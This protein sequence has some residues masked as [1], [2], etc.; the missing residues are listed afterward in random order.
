[1]RNIPFFTAHT[2]HKYT[3][4]RKLRKGAR[5][6]ISYV[7]IT[8]RQLFSNSYAL[9]DLLS[10]IRIFASSLSVFWN[11]NARRRR[12]SQKYPPRV[13][14]VY[15]VSSLLSPLSGSLMQTMILIVQT[16]LVV[17]RSS[18]DHAKEQNRLLTTLGQNTE[19]I[20]HFRV[21]RCILLR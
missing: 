21:S 12:L 4:C 14:R 2:L 20:Q 13:E 9:V 19:F 6:I 17:R 7:C 1:M 18:H 3:H 16:N 8:C 5:S 10:R 15:K 11:G